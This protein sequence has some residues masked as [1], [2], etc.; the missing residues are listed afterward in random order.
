M[1]RGPSRGSEVRADDS[2]E[3]LG[4]A[5]DPRRAEGTLSQ[6]LVERLRPWIDLDE[7]GVPG[8][9]AFVLSVLPLI[10]RPRVAVATAREGEPER[11]V[12]ELARALTE[13]AGDRARARFQASLYFQENRVLARRVRALE[14]ILR[15]G[16]RARE[17]RA[18]PMDP[19]ADR[20]T[21]RYLPRARGP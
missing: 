8:L 14:A 15:M 2:A 7:V 17:A 10:P 9:E 16:P 6:D 21:G 19:D 1:P 13:C 3:A 11:R 12:R 18:I 4:D 5:G 20:A